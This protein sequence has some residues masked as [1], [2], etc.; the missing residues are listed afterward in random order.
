MV[1]YIVPSVESLLKLDRRCPHCGRPNGNIHSGIGHRSISDWK[2]EVIAQRRMKCPDCGLTWTL[3]ADGVGPGRQRSDRLIGMGVILY[4][5]GLS[6]RAVQQFLPYL[7]CRGGKSSIERDV[8]RAG[9]NARDLHQ[10]APRIRV[11]VLGVDGTGAAMA[12]RSAG[13]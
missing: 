12:G 1:R 5:L 9:E 8:T 2:V 7:D 4:M 10:A 6:Y 13:V 11:R 3:R